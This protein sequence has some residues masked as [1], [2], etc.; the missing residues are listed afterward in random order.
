MGAYFQRPNDHVGGH[1]PRGPSL[2]HPRLDGY[3]KLPSPRGNGSTRVGHL[4]PTAHPCQ[5]TQERRMTTS[6]TAAPIRNDPRDG[7]TPST[8]PRRCMLCPRPR[9]SGRGR[10]CSDACRQR[11]FRLRHTALPN[12]E[13]ELL[14]KALRQRAALIAHT[15]YECTACDVRYLGERRCSECNHFCRVVGLGGACQDCEQPILLS[16]LLDLEV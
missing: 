9:R 12:L 7:P 8:A 16:D 3:G 14:R 15:I 2:G 10:F 6:T 13:E 5:S 1:R 4:Q 11:A